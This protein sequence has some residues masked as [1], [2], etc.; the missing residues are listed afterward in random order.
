VNEY[1]RSQFEGIADD[2]VTY[3]IPLLDK[4]CNMNFLADLCVREMKS[5]GSSEMGISH[6]FHLPAILFLTNRFDECAES[7]RLA[8]ARLLERFSPE[9]AHSKFPRHYHYFKRLREL[10]AAPR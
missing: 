7:L 10:L 5:P 1:G 3:G 8:E 2:L 4:Y 9:E 6:S